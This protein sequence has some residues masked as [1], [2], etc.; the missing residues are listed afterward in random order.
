MLHSPSSCRR[1]RRNVIIGQGQIEVF[2]SSSPFKFNVDMRNQF[3]QTQPER[4]EV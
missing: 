4:Y 1:D 3:V 2:G